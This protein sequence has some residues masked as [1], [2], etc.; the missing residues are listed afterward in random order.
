MRDDMIR[1]RWIEAA[2]ILGEDPSAKVPCPVCGNDFLEVFDVEYGHDPVM[3]DR[4]LTCPSC[5]AQE[6]LSRL[7]KR[8]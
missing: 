6:V 7:R 3:F 4:Y 1:Q 5:N 8:Q 2:R